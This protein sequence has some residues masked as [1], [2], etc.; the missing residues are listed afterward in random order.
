MVRRALDQPRLTRRDLGGDNQAIA[1]IV[2]WVEVVRSVELPFHEPTDFE[3]QCELRR[4]EVAHW[5]PAAYALNV[6]LCVRQVIPE[7]GLYP[8]L[9]GIVRTGGKTIDHR[10]GGF[11]PRPFML[12]ATVECRSSSGV[13]FRTSMTSIPRGSR[14]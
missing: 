2:V 5:D 6:T 4:D 12:D 14:A 11:L 1:P 10:A 7:L 9:R 3:Q 13:G 8:L